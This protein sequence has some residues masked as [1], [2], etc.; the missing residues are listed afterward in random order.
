MK[1]GLILTGGRIDLAFAGPFLREAG[2]FDCVVA[3][4][5]GLAAAEELGLAPAA[6]VGDFDSADPRLLSRY[7]KRPGIRWDVRRPE[8][9]ETDTE[10]AIG[11][12]LELGCTRLCILGATGGRLDHEL[13]NIHLLKLC[14]DRGAEACIC[15]ACNRLFLIGPPG[16]TFRRDRVW[17]KYVSFLPLSQH[18]RGITLSGFKYPLCGKDLEIGA[19]AGLCVSNEMAGER[20]EIALREGVLVCV[21]S[22][23]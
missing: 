9:D 22:R 11:T 21:E 13:S 12:A 14:L 4:D 5:A 17:G 7:R 1:T 18:V 19:E 8:K 6:V 15:D 3:A 2:D 16:R 23:D 20:A 10:L